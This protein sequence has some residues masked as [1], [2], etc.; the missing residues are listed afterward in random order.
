MA[1]LDDITRKLTMTLTLKT[2]MRKCTVAA[3]TLLAAVVPLGAQAH[4]LWVFP[5][6]TVFSGNDAWVT[7][8]AAVS[9]ELFYPDAF[10]LR[11][12]G[13]TVTAPDGKAVAAENASTGRHRSVF[14]V[15]LTEAGTYRVALVS[16]GVFVTFKENGEARRWRGTVEGMKKVL[17]ADAQ[18]VQVHENDIRIESFVTLGKP[19]ARALAPTGH[20]LEL[21]PITHP[22]DLVA[23][24]DASFELRMD[25]QPAAN[26]AVVIIPGGIRYRDALGEIKATSDAKGQFHVRWPQAGMYWVSAQLQDDHASLPQAKGRR[27]VYA[28]TLEVLPQ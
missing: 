16:Q 5:S 3:A 12:D 11:L 24:Q 17:P 20:G 18:D 9:N 15:H 22:N 10:A 13:L 19:D 21:V 7:M 28:A 25:G 27:V 1:T 4:R 23:G 26:L 6:G 14:D 2:T 8:D